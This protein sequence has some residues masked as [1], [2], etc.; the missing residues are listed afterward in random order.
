MKN[1]PLFNDD[2]ENIERA[3]RDIGFINIYEFQ[4]SKRVALTN[5]WEPEELQT[6]EDL[7][8][9]VGAGN[10]ELIGR[11]RIKK[12]IVDR[13]MIA[14]KAP[15]NAQ[16]QDHSDE[17]PQNRYRPEPP[18]APAVPTVPSMQGGGITIPP[19]TD[20]TMAMFMMLVTTQQQQN[21]AQLA[22]Q[23]EDSRINMQS[24]TQ[25]LVGFTSAQA[26]MVTGLA[27]ALNGGARAPGDG[28]SADAFMKGVETMGNLVQG[29][30]E[31]SEEAE[32]KAL[33]IGEV[34]KNIADSLG[35]VRDIAKATSGVTSGTAGAVIPPGGP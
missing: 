7:Y 23:R 29:L 12:T 3:T 26:Q 18:A 10:F 17:P 11:D 28:S 25:L 14:L 15:K 1:H 24:M 22:A 32:P 30:R 34:A 16:N 35:A 27:G 13:A 19:G 5:Q 6:L 31:G 8:A 33:N 21:A 2:P 20:P 4:G 9:A